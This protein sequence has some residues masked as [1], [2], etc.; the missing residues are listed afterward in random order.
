MDTHTLTVCS[1]C[2]RV[3]RGSEWVAPEPVIRELRTFTFER[4]PR[5]ESAVCPHCDE[6][7]RRRRARTREPVAA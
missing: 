2:L 1:I 4:A 5:L 6:S 3:L 7:I